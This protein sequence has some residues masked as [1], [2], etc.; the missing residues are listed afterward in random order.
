MKTTAYSKIDRTMPVRDLIEEG[1]EL[2]FSVRRH[3]PVNYRHFQY[4]G[5]LFASAGHGIWPPFSIKK[6]YEL[7]EIGQTLRSLDEKTQTKYGSRG[8]EPGIFAVKIVG[9]EGR[10]DT[11]YT[12]RHATTT[13]DEES[14]SVL[15]VGIGQARMNDRGLAL[16]AT[17]LVLRRSLIGDKETLE[18]RAY[19]R[20]SPNAPEELV[21][22]QAIPAPEVCLD[23][24]QHHRNAMWNMAA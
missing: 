19:V 20:H 14:D 15:E 6:V 5:H 24:L 18:A 3:R 21:V 17:S 23:F 11:D 2:S 7:D 4:S 10:A 1:V 22:A 9:D 13:G 16:F 8:W 12:H